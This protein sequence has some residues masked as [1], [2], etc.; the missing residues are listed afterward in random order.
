MIVKEFRNLIKM[1]VFKSLNI[2]PQLL[3]SELGLGF[4]VRM[5]KDIHELPDNAA[6]AVDKTLILALQLC[7]GLLVLHR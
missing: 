7:N 6:E 5:V 3:Q 2:F 1:R 4:A